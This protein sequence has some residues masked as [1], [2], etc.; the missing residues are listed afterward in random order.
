[1]SKCVVPV[2]SDVVMTRFITEKEKALETPTDSSVV[3]SCSTVYSGDETSRGNWSGRMDFLLSCIGYAVG[4]GN[5]WRF[6]YLC[7]KSGG[8]AFLIPYLIFLVLCGIPLFFLEVSYGQFASLSPITVWR[9]C[10]LFKGV[11]YGMVIISGIVCIYY[12]IIITWTIY[13]LYYS[14]RA[15]LPWSTCDNWWNTEKCF[16]RTKDHEKNTTLVTL[17]NETNSSNTSW[18][19]DVSMATP[20]LAD[21]D[22]KTASEEFWQRAVLQMSDGIDDMGD[23]RWDLLICL[24]VAWVIVFLCLFKGVKSS[25]KVVYVTATFPYLVL[26]ILLVR[27][28]TLPGA[29]AGI[30]FY[31]VPDWNKLATFE[32]W[33]DAAVQIFY[34]VG[35]AWGGLITMASYNKFHNNVYRDAMV[36]PLI[37]CGTSVFAGLVIFS[38]LGFM[39]H[40]TGV[41]IEKVV[42]QGPGLTFVAYPEAVAKLPISPLWAVLFFLMLFTIGLDSQF[43]MFE[44]MTSAFV[45]EFPDLLKNR[46][47]LFTA[48]MCFI[49]FLLG[50]PCVMQ[51]GVYV[52]QIMD[53]YCSTFS[54]MILSLTECIVIGWI[55]GADRFYRD[56]ELMIGYQP[57]VWW[58]I[59]W[60][61]ITPILILFIWLFS[62]TQL[63]PVTYGDYHYPQWAI[64]LGWF[65]GL[66]SLAPV[67][68][69]AVILI[70]KETGP[71]MLRVKKLLKP[72]ENF[73]PAVPKYREE[74]VE[75]LEKRQSYFPTIDLRC[76][77]TGSSEFIQT[78]ETQNFMS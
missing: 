67:P 58:K 65:L 57:C 42:T 41:D 62:V 32:V 22:T 74:Y 64:I 1:M 26:L 28:V 66:I 70:F 78:G 69:C 13:F 21:N 36:V 19:Y 6:P 68:I 4:L 55:Y 12:N 59:S 27:G 34:S 76:R 47:E 77:H 15:V 3:S 10:P 61:Y 25:G 73:G 16:L 48:F 9:I 7:Y 35:M 2:D 33:G 72:A 11:G 14:F 45:D 56:I 29:G 39:A 18:S 53:W 30:Y 23:L 60:C 24:F 54:L 49:E 46:K 75:T 20:L 52:L 31:L 5:I 37:N 71:I 8:G 43:G 40:E 63:S 51:G 38:V 50:I 44:T 17:S